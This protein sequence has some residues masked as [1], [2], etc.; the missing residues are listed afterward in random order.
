[1]AEL[2]NYKSRQEVELEIKIEE[3]K[4]EVMGNNCYREIAQRDKIA[5]GKMMSNLNQDIK[6]Q[7]KFLDVSEISQ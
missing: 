7:S 5:I 2:E 3:L 4:I 1:M 6:E